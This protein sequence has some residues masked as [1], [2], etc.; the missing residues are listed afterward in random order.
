[1]SVLRGH[2]FS[3]LFGLFDYLAVDLEVMGCDLWRLAVFGLHVVSPIACLPGVLGE[4]AATL[5]VE[6]A[7]AMGSHANSLAVREHGDKYG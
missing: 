7:F 5:P 2:R 4:R 6:F 3:C 1:M